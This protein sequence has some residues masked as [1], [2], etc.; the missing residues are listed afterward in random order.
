[1]SAIKHRDG[2]FA[3]RITL[4]DGYTIPLISMTADE[5]DL[6]R[7]LTP[8]NQQDFLRNLAIYHLTNDTAQELVKRIKAITQSQ[9]HINT[10]PLRRQ[11]YAPEIITAISSNLTLMIARFNINIAH[12]QNREWEVGKHKIY[13]EPDTRQSGTNLTI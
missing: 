11:Y 4:T 6:Y 1:M 8:D 12:G 7:R 5:S 9:L 3:Y 13:D 10:L 2:S